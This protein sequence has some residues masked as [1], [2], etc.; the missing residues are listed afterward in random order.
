V[1]GSVL[2]AVPNGQLSGARPIDVLKLRGETEV[3]ERSKRR[4]LASTPELARWNP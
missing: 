1:T 3:L 2:A 4:A